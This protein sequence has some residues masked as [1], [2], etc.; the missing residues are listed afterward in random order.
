MF[1]YTNL[2]IA[3]ICYLQI[4]SCLPTN[5]PAS[6]SPTSITTSAPQKPTS[7]STDT[8]KLTTSNNGVIT[9]SSVPPKNSP[10]N[11]AS[12]T[13]PESS[14]TLSPAEKAL[15]DLFE[16]LRNV[17][18][19]DLPKPED[20]AK[21]LREIDAI[22]RNNAVHDRSEILK[23]IVYEL[24]NNI[25]DDSSDSSDDDSS[26]SSEEGFDIIFEILNL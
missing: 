5:Q 23:R 8:S 12:T 15:Q 16:I 7:D 10:S 24:F 3:I 17:S 4:V 13:A 6:E 1:S 22:L 21:I 2:T 11:E 26:G 14:T 20:V 18:N 19:N 25:F 9:A